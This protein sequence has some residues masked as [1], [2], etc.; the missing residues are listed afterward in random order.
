LSQKVSI[1]RFLILL[2]EAK[3]KSPSHPVGGCGGV[4]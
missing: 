2:D 3:K 1:Y 4:V